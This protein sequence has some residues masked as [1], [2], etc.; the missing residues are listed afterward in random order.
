MNLASLV[1]AKYISEKE[2]HLTVQSQSYDDEK[3]K[4]KKKKTGATSSKSNKNMVMFSEKII[5]TVSLVF[6]HP[7]WYPFNLKLNI[8][9][10]H[11]I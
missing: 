3:E 7:I 2:K 8:I 5:A 9:I 6:I 10:F 4:P 11:A 1:F